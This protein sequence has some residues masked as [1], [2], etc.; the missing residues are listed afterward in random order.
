VTNRIGIISGR[1]DG[2]SSTLGCDYSGRFAVVN[3]LVP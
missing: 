2:H 3:P 1:L